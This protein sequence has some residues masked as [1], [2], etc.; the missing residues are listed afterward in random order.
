MLFILQ[1]GSNVMQIPGTIPIFQKKNTALGVPDSGSFHY[2][3]MQS[4]KN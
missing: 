3:N 1:F 2:I 4:R